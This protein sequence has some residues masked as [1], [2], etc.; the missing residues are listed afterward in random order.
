[1]PLEIRQQ[2]KIASMTFSYVLTSDRRTQG[3]PAILT[4]DKIIILC[5]MNSTFKIILFLSM[6]GGKRRTSKNPP[7]RIY[8]LR[9]LLE[10]V[11]RPKFQK[12]SLKAAKG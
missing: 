3:T 2:F 7:Y 12:M 10:R 4:I 6:D 9:Y 11:M 5:E 1:V 8:Y